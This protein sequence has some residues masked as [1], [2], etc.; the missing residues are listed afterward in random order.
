MEEDEVFEFRGGGVHLSERLD[1]GRAS[2]RR[3]EVRIARNVYRVL[4]AGE[5]ESD[6]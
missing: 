6:G 2:E 1:G 3:E 5:N 4:K